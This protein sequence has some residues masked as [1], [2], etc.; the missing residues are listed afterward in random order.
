MDINVLLLSLPRLLTVAAVS[1]VLELTGIAPEIMIFSRNYFP[2]SRG[3][4]QPNW[5]ENR[6]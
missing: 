6:I 3:I 4:S 1:L 5:R 2:K